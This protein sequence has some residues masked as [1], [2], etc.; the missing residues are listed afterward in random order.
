MRR[1][2]DRKTIDGDSLHDCNSTQSYNTLLLCFHRLPSPFP[3]ATTTLH[4]VSPRARI[5]SSP[6]TPHPLFPPTNSSQ[7][8]QQSIHAIPSWN[9]RVNASSLAS[10]FFHS[11]SRLHHLSPCMRGSFCSF[12][13]FG[14]LP[15][16]QTLSRLSCIFDKLMQPA[17]QSRSRAAI[18][19]LLGNIL[20]TQTQFSSNRIPESWL[21]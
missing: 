13:A 11:P 5:A 1:W 21:R 2:L 6:S 8:Q 18:S 4:S 14:H 19:I 20:R 3:P 16:P 12:S 10:F 15:D 7:P 17:H 9:L